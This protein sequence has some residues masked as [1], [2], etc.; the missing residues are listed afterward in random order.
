MDNLREKLREVMLGYA[1]RG[2]ND[3]SYLTANED[4]SLFAV[5]SIG[6]WDGKHVASA[7]LI[8]RLVDDWI[9]IDLDMNDRIL[10]DALVQAGIP[11]QKIILTYA[12]ETLP[13]PEVYAK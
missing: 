11:R 6:Q 9:M 8:V 5:V 13:E 1:G 4:Q 3:V 2:F 7:G 10:L 12:G